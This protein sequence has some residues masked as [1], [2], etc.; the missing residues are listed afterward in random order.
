M[1]IQGRINNRSAPAGRNNN[2]CPECKHDILKEHHT[3][4]GGKTRGYR[5]GYC[6]RCKRICECIKEMYEA[7]ED[8]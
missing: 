2:K 3:P 7:D 6:V 8:G 1:F 4:E 5:L